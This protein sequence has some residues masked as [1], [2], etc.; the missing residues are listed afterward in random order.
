LTTCCQIDILFTMSRT[1]VRT[2]IGDQFTYLV[3]ATFRL[4]G[5]LTATG[6]RMV[7][8]LG[9]STARWQVLGMIVDRPLSVSAIAR[10]VGVTRQSVQ[11]TADRLAEDG[12]V[13]TIHNPDHRS[14]KLYQLTPMGERVMTEVQHRQAAWANRMAKGLDSACFS[15]T[16]A[17]I[18]ALLER[19]ESDSA[20]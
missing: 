6:D 16:Q 13:D 8:D 5:A 20:E 9:L 11:R 3:L 12:F 15:T 4:H 19:L 1:I 17:L 2:K 18:Q 7:E 10:R 14:A